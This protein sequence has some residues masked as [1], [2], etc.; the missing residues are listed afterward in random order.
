MNAQGELR[1]DKGS[2][3]CAERN[4]GFKN[5]TAGGKVDLF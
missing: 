3:V 2:D 5:L 1:Y 4:D